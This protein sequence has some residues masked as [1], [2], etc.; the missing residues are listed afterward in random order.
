MNQALVR[1]C[2]SCGAAGTASTPCRH[3]LSHSSGH[4]CF[5]DRSVLVGIAFCETGGHSIIA[6]D[7]VFGKLAVVVFVEPT[8][9]GGDDE[10]DN[11]DQSVV[12]KVYDKYY[13]VLA[14]HIQGNYSDKIYKLYRKN[15]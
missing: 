2:S 4:F 13:N 14:D 1:R 12:D 5:V 3:A 11:Y 10:D 6:S 15:K 9:D 7:L 8:E